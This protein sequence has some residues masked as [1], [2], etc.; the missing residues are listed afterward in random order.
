MNT[1]LSGMSPVAAA[2]ASAWSALAEGVVVPVAAVLVAAE[3]VGEA[4]VA[5]V[6]VF[7]PPQP[8][9]TKAALSVLEAIK[10]RGLAR[11]SDMLRAGA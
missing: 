9:S 2:F 5:G 3:V 6:A 11:I 7:L 8:V 10:S 4:D 1:W